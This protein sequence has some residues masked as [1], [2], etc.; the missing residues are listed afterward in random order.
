MNIRIMIDGKITCITNGKLST[1][2]EDSL[3]H[4]LFEGDKLEYVGDI[5]IIYWNLKKGKWSAHNN[6]GEGISTRSFKYA[7]KIF[8]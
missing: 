7:K 4:E 5:Y 8:N 1:L 2:L 3:G 6:A